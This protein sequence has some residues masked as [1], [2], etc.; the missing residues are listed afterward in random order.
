M[1]A[2]KSMEETATTMV[3]IILP[4]VM[5]QSNM[6]LGTTSTRTHT[7]IITK[8][9]LATD[10]LESPRMRMIVVVIADVAIATVVMTVDGSSLSFVVGQLEATMAVAM[11]A[12][13]EV[14]V[15]ANRRI[16]SK[17]ITLG[18]RQLRG[19]NHNSKIGQYTE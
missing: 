6:I 10:N 19:S 13:V 5:V 15:V 7:I 11:I 17:K 3:G 18:L 4:L 12:D 2:T 16:G 1:Q 8:T 9:T 14:V